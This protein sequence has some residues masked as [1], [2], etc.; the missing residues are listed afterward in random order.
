MNTI[1]NGANSSNDAPG[2]KSLHEADVTALVR[3]IMGEADA[4]SV[5]EALER[6]AQDLDIISLAVEQLHADVEGDEDKVSFAVHRAA[7]RLRV[8][9]RIAARPPAYGRVEIAGAQCTTD[10][11]AE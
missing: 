11:E 7:E 6:V 5:P 10:A 1:V 3:T 9:A 2:T 8:M 4:P